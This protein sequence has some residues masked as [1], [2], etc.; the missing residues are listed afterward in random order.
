[1]TRM[2]LLLLLLLPGLSQGLKLPSYIKACSQHDPNINACAKKHGIEAIPHF[3]NGDPKYKV[4][5]L[6]PLR[7][8]KLS[9]THEKSNLGLSSL[10][11]T[12]AVISG[13]EN[14]QLE[15][16]RIDLSKRHIEIDLFFPSIDIDMKYN[17]EGKALILP[18]TG[19]GPGNM[20]L[21]NVTTG[22]DFDFKLVW[23]NA[24][25]L[26]HAIPQHPVFKF[27]AGR[28][29]VHLENLFNGDKFLGEA[30]NAF[31]NENWKELRREFGPALKEAISHIFLRI[32]SNIFAL[33][34]YKDAF[35]ESYTTS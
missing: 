28:I 32:I 25:G 17:I 16:I 12:D 34:P 20:S 35:L 29:F 3:L 18:I 11:V 26:D 2:L 21:K 31:L 5:S 7:V 13:I 8:D 14:V 23:N 1:M 33:V 19:S 4:P 22:V 24:T 10:V 9:V 15:D 30:M 27:D 6:L